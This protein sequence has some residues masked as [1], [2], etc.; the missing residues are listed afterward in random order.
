MAERALERI[1]HIVNLDGPLAVEGKAFKDML[2]DVWEHFRQRGR[3]AGDEWWVPPIPEWTFGVTGPDLEWMLSK[4]TSHPLRTWETPLSLANP[5]AR[6]VPR[7]F[8][9]CIEGASIHD[10][11]AQ[12][13]EYAAAGWNYRYIAT[14][15]DAMITAPDELAKILL[16][17]AERE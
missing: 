6:A 15:H 2:P 11:A 7:T 1:A 12:T 14:G 3:E 4:L 8:I 5:A 13:Q 16:E 9:S 10:I 17:L